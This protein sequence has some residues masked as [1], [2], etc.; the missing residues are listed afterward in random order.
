MTTPQ[1]LEAVLCVSGSLL[2][3]EIQV[4]PVAG[5][6]GAQQRGEFARLGNLWRV[7]WSGLPGSHRNLW[8]AVGVNMTNTRGMRSDAAGGELATR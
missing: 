3:P 1:A 7:L 6:Q 8:K 4:N 2:K 5:V